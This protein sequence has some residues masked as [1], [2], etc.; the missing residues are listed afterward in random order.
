MEASGT[1]SASRP[2]RRKQGIHP[3][4]ARIHRV[5]PQPFTQ[6]IAGSNPAGVLASLRPSASVSGSRRSSAS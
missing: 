5:L 6:E 3:H 1:A 4:P 2:E